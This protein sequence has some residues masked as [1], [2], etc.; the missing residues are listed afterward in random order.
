[1]GMSNWAS[2]KIQFEKTIEL[3]KDVS[4]AEAKYRLGEI[5]YKQK[6]YDASIKTMQELAS[7]YSDFLEWYENAFL[8]IADNYLGKNDS[9]M[10]KATLNSI[11][12][13][14]ENAETVAKA[15]QKLNAIK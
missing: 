15:R 7:N 3:G 1:M 2:A 10:A 11:I 9:F 13:N 12:E 6:E 8:L 4:A 14:S 5:Q